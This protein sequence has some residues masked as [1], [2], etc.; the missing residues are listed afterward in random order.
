MNKIIIVSTASILTLFCFAAK[1]QT[2]SL[3]GKELY[4]SNFSI[5]G[6]QR[7]FTYY[8]PVE[9]GRKDVYPLI[10]VLSDSTDNAISIIKKYGD[11]IQAK[12]DSFNCIVVYASPVKN[13]WN[14]KIDSTPVSAQR[15]NDFGFLN[16]LIDYFIQQ[17]SAD[18]K[19][20][21][22]CGFFDGGKMASSLSC[23]ISYKIGASVSFITEDENIEKRCDSS[24]S[25]PMMINKLST[26]QKPEV[27][28]VLSAMDFL[29]DHKQK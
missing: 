7:N 8:M 11:A 12:A 21:G 29:L 27:K 14:D 19:Q 16:I 6:V 9:Y 10:L 13:D 5:D 2:D 22:V 20:V 18:G 1:S 24:A 4:S 25:I 23:K 15:I 26:R 28:E 17:Y 3:K